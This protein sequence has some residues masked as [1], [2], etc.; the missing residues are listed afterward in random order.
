MSEE[1]EGKKCPRECWLRAP[2]HPRGTGR[3]R[4]HVGAATIRR[5]L[6]ASRTGPA[7]RDADTSC[8]AFLHTQAS[9]LLA[10]DF[11]HLDATMVID[12]PSSSNRARHVAA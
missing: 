2:P 3:P 5:I 8:R 7:P 1:P 9:G 12:A 6:S 10:T 11:F 4:H